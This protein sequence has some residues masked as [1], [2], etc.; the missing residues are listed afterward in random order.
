MD[1]N[2]LNTD[3][4]Q[5]EEENQP[6][7]K[8]LKPKFSPVAAAFIAVFLIFILYQGIGGMLT[9]LILG[10]DIKKMDPTL[11]RLMTIAGQT[12]FILLPTL[13]LSKVIFEDVSTIIRFKLP[14]LK[15]IGIFFLGFLI[16]TPLLQNLTYIQTYLIEKYAVSSSFIHQFKQFFDSMDQYLG[17]S[18]SSLFS[19][20]SV[21]DVILI[22]ITISVT[23]AICEEVFFRGFVQKSFELKWKPFWSIAVTSLVFSLYHFSPYGLIPLFLLS[24]FLGYA[25][26]KSGSIF[27]PM[28][29]HFAN[30]FI[31]IILYFVVGAQ[32]VDNKPDPKLQIS[33]FLV[34]LFFNVIAFIIWFFFVHRYYR[35]TETN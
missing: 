31:M 3:Q 4:P 32:A 7:G 17:D 14:R 5:S 12:L 16:I 26:Y 30:N 1:E 11:L 33:S 20:K 34:L 23:P 19:V 15:E 25:A 6:G 8:R 21:F 28:S 27:V 22:V 9:V 10:L 2:N 35:K 18:Y 13:I 24:A 29:I